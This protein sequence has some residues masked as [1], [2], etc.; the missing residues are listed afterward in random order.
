MRR[1]L[2]LAWLSTG[3]ASGPPTPEPTAP[4]RLEADDDR[5][6]TK[7]P[8]PEVRAPGE[9]CHATFRATGDDRADVTRLA[10]ACQ[11]GERLGDTQGGEQSAE[12]PVARFAFA[13]KA[14]AC[15]R[16]FAVGGDGVVELDTMLRGP[17]GRPIVVDESTG[18]VA[19]MP[20]AAAVCLATDGVYTIEVS[21][22]RGRGRFSVELW[23]Q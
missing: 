7:A 17:D 16:V 21:V 3:C 20:R 6:T 22:A 2:L 11:A 1:L 9:E 10:R 8:A 15:H 19:V 14:G 5:P 18:R 23:K 12:S 4:R 13:G